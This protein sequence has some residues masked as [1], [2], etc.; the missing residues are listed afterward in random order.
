MRVVLVASIVLLAALA[1]CT[2]EKKGDEPSSS[3]TTST[4]ASASPTAAPT[5]KVASLLANVTNG[6]APLLV[7]FTLN[8]TAGALNWTLS[9]GDGNVTNGTSAPPALANHTYAIAGNFSANLTVN[10]AGGAK[11]N[12]TLAINVTLTAASKAAPPDVLVFTFA[13]SLGCA[14]DLGA[15][16]C[17]SFQG[18]PD[19]SGID[20]YWQALDERYWGLSF[21]GTVDQVQPAVAD[22]D[23]AFTD[24]AF[25]II[26]EANNTSSPCSGTVPAGTAWIFVYPYA[27]PALEQTLTF[28]V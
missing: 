11:A 20:G 24:A 13:D 28:T 18:G 26:G 15:D 7:N 8:A 10:Y 22:S 5:P 4:G 19:A 27:L 2:A 9:F 16:N 1:G 6:T 17:V 21:V 3:A 14:G 12:A 23:C 25:A